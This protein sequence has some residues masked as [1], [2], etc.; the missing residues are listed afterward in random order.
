MVMQDKRESIL[1]VDDEA[2]VVEFMVY[3]LEE[4][5]YRVKGVTS[6]IEAIKM[7]RNRQFDL[8]CI[9]I[10]MPELS[11]VVT[12]EKIL[13]ISPDIEILIVTGRPDSKVLSLCLEK[14]IAHYLFKPFQGP[15]LVYSVFAAL[16]HRRVRRRLATASRTHSPFVGISQASQKIRGQIARYSASSLP[17]LVL[18]ESGTGKEI[19]A[20]ELHRNSSRSDGPFIPVNCATLGELADSQLFGHCKGAFTGAVS[21][22][23]GYI[24]EAN[25]GTLFLDEIGEL[26]YSSQAKLLRFLDNKEYSRVGE[27]RVRRSDVRVIAA[28]NR[29]LKG[30]CTEGGFRKDLY[31]RLAAIVIEIPP[32]RERP[33]D[34]PPLVWHF[35]EEY[36]GETGRYLSISSDALMVMADYPWPGNVRQ[37]KNVVWRVCE[38]SRGGVIRKMDLLNHLDVVEMAI[39]N[40]QEAK[41]SALAAFDR[42]YFTRLILA[43]QGSLK[44]ALQLSGMHKKNFY[45][46]LKAIGLSMRSLSRM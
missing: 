19:V 38:E 3:T 18:G 6:A 30:L 13:D 25:G 27:A 8:A 45:M 17:V 29:D 36:E 42:E 9:D 4:A 15:Q 34:I 23:K 21:S 31:Y 28:T 41:R 46:K 39:E 26:P 20:R 40:Y 11:G 43:S 5:G 1:V 2:P 37:L 10:S 16:Y 44:K 12:A 32:L 35:L 7:C 33:E 14:G 24:G 22:S